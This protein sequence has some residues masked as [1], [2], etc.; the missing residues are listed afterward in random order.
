MPPPPSRSRWICAASYPPQIGCQAGVPCSPAPPR[1]LD[2]ADLASLE[3]PSW[4]GFGGHEWA[5]MGHHQGYMP[6][7]P[8]Q[9]VRW[10]MNNE[11]AGNTNFGETS[12]SGAS[13]RHTLII[14]CAYNARPVRC[15]ALWQPPGMHPDDTTVKPP[16]PGIGS[17]DGSS[18]RV[19]CAFPQSVRPRVLHLIPSADSDGR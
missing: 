17:Y 1:V 5:R 4:N 19:S 8:R 3:P 18:R 11:T 6:S 15:P 2:D 7:S 12:R 10:N 9:C 16:R 14:T 13:A